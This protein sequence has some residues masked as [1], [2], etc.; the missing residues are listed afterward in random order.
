VSSWRTIKIRTFPVIVLS[1][2]MELSPDITVYKERVKE[3]FWRE[4]E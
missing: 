3:K 2:V 4:K 1:G